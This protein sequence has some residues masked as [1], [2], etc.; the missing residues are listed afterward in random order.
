MFPDT[1]RQRIKPLISCIKLRFISLSTYLSRSPERQS[2]FFIIPLASYL[3]LSLL[4]LY[5]NY[6][7]I[8]L[9][10]VLH[11][12]QHLVIKEFSVSMHFKLLLSHDKRCIAVGNTSIK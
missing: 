4:L 5:Y 6:Q 9:L 12:K 8:Y 1:A 11:M 7:H 2:Q 3:Y 10:H